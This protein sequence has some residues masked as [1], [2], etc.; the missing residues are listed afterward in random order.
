VSEG[1]AALDT[2][3]A[4]F[5]RVSFDLIYARPGRARPNGRP[6]CARAGFGTGHLSLYQLTIEPGTRFATLAAKGRAR[7][8]IP[9]RRRPVRADPRDDRRRRP[10]RLRN[11]EPCAPRRGEPPQS[12]LLALCRL[13]GV[14]PGAHGR[15]GAMA[16]VRHKKPE[17]WLARVAA[18]SHGIEQ[19]EALDPDTRRTE[20]LLMGLRLEEGVPI[21]RIAGAFDP[22]AVDRLASHGLIERTPERLR[23]L[24]PGMLLLDAIL[25]KIAV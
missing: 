23:V 21:A 4:A 19:E 18:N 6:S 20:A 7:P 22:D 12:R 9:M 13:S 24:P 25:S 2:A 17:N 3:Q 10:A 8:S 11:L 16:T 5:D 14:G 1:L 15:R